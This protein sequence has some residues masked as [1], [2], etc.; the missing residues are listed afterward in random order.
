MALTQDFCI[1]K[2]GKVY[3]IRDYDNNYQIVGQI[4]N[5]EA[6]IRV[7]GEGA[8]VALAF[9]HPD[10][11]FKTT[12]VNTALYP[13]PND[14]TFFSFCEKYPY[15]KDIMPDGKQ[16]NTFLMRKTKNVYKADGS[17]WGTV[18]SGKRVASNNS[19]VGSTHIDWKEINYVERTDGTWV[20]VNGAGVE[21]GYVDT[22]ISTASGYSTIPFYGS[23]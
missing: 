11:K 22:G 7:G 19:N 9:L 13:T 3:T 6:F 23:W 8:L 5:R 15:K 20:K 18:A 17:F 14:N 1:N 12:I 10:G 16:Y 21:C 4:N 2:S